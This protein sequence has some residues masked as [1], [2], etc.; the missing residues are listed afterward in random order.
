MESFTV[1]TNSIEIKNLK[2]VYNGTI[3]ICKESDINLKSDIVGVYGQNGSGK[4][5]IIQTLVLFKKIV[6]GG[7]IR[8]DMNYCISVDK[9]ECQIKF[10]FFIIANENTL[11]SGNSDDSCINSVP[12][13]VEQM[14]GKFCLNTATVFLS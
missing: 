8:N 4:T 12:E 10:V 5:A 6:S 3:D 2:N 1:I 9:D 11:D 7:H 14:P 13:K